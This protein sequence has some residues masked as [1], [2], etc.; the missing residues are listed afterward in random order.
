MPTYEYEC[1]ACGHVFEAFHSMSAHPIKDCPECGGAVRRLPGIGAGVL[2]KGSGFYET[3]YRSREYKKAA[4]AEQKDASA[5]KKDEKSAS[6]KD[7]K[8]AE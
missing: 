3:D 2:F 8:K 1:T 6:N 7:S 5:A 4:S